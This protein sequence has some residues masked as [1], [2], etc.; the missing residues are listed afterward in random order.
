MTVSK[1]TFI[2][3]VLLK[4]GIE[5]YLTDFDEKY[6]ELN[7]DDMEPK[8]TLLMFASEPYPFLKKIEEVSKLPFP[9][10]I[11][12]GEYYSWFGLRSLIFLETQVEL[13]KH[14]KMTFTIKNK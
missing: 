14:P 5:K 12:N 13:F 2:S 10:L 1:K 3:S 6:P 8:S 4:L 7:L 11:L 9:S